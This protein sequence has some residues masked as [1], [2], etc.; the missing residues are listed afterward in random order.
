MQKEELFIKVIWFSWKLSELYLEKW[1][2]KLEKNL[3]RQEAA[4]GVE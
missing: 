2:M 3:F 1:K 4:E